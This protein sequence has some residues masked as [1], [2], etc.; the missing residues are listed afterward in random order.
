MDSMGITA[1]PGFHI[2]SS[3]WVAGSLH[4]LCRPMLLIFRYKPKENLDVAN[5]IGYTGK[6]VL[7][8]MY[9]AIL[10]PI[11]NFHLIFTPTFT[12]CVD[13]CA[14]WNTKPPDKC[15]GV[16]WIED[17]Y[18]PMGVS[19]GSLCYFIWTNPPGWGVLTTLLKFKV[20]SAPL[21]R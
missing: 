11:L 21:Q 13:E 6:V 20:N 15:L 19:R 14:T 4:N 2:Q 3:R 18:G 16:Q 8:L 1:P 5:S 10:V 9:F 17:N 7:C 12:C